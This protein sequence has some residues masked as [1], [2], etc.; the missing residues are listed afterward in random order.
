M[1]TKMKLQ[2]MQCS[3]LFLAV[4]I[5]VIGII[6]QEYESVFNKAINICLECIGIG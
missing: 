1:I 2:F 6:N 4:I 3:I 5:M